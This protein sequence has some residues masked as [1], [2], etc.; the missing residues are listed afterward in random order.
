MRIK[1]FA[2]NN[3]ET[4]EN[5]VNEFLKTLN[6]EQIVDIKYSSSDNYCEVVIVYRV[7]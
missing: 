6:V 4:L 7:D 2:T 1:L 5:K 3:A